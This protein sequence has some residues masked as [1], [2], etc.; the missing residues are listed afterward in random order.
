MSVGRGRLGLAVGSFALFALSGFVGLAVRDGA[1]PLRVDNVAAR[2]VDSAKL[3]TLLTAAQG[4]HLRSHAF[5]EVMTSSGLP[6]AAAFVAVGLAVIAWRRG[7]QRGL[8]LC[9]L[10]PPIAV[11]LADVVAKPVVGRH[12]HGG[13]SYPSGHATGAAAVAVL[14][15]LLLY[16]WGGSRALLRVGPLALA[17]P[18]LMGLALVRSGWHYPTDVVGG[19]AMGA[20]TMLALAAAIGFREPGPDSSLG[21]PS[22]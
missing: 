16:R 18:L 17:L 13:L 20:A 21:T 9:W 19:V 8:A 1:R 2:I 10:G 12:R 4:Q 15:L 14:V 3:E 5:L 6:A 22:A 7:D 11:V